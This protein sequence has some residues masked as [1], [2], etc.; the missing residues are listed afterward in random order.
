[1]Y[2]DIIVDISHENLDREFQY[3]IPEKLKE[4]AVIGAS[5]EIPF[6]S[7]N[8]S[9]K[10][11]IVGISD[12]PKI[13]AERIKPLLSIEP[14]GIRIESRMIALAGKMR[15]MYGGTMNDALRTVMPVKRSIRPVSERTVSLACSHEE[16]ESF[17]NEAERKHRTAQVR[18]IRELIGEPS[19]D[20]LLLVNKL[21][22]SR[23]TISDL[24]SNGI[25]RITTER[26]YRNPGQAGDD[27]KKKQIE[28]NEEQQTAIDAV[29]SDYHT[30]KRK[31][32][33][34]HGV[35]G[36]GKTEVYL[37]VIEEVVKLGY[38]VIM[39]IPEIALT[40]Q[41]M[42]RFQ[43]RFGM[44]VSFL[45]SR[46]SEGERYDQYT[47]AEQGEIDI[48]IGPRSA[49]FTPFRNPGLIIIDEEHENSYKSEQVPKYHAR[50]LAIEYAKMISA[51]VVL[52]SATPSLE[53]FYRAKTGEYRLL[54][55]TN[56][57]GNAQMP[58]VHIVDMREELKARNLSIFSR[59]LRTLIEDRLLHHQQVMLF[60]NRRGFA[61]FVSCRNCGESMQ[62]PHCAVSLTA[63][64][65]RRL[66]CHYCGYEQEMPQVCPVCGSKYIA[67]FGTGTEKVEAMVQREFPTAK[68]LRMDADTTRK[69]EGHEQILAAF[70]NEEADILVGTQMIVKGHDF[71]RVTLMGVLA[72]DLSLS[73]TDYR[74]AERTFQLLAQAAGRSGR[75]EEAGEVVIQTYR[76]EHYSIQAA[77]HEDYES[78]YRNEMMYRTA[79]GYPPA[80]NLAAILL[81]AKEEEEA[82][83]GAVF[84]TDWVKAW[85]EENDSL[86]CAIVIGPAPAGIAKLRDIYRRVIYIKHPDYPILT[87]CRDAVEEMLR[88]EDTLRE[89]NIQFDFNPMNNY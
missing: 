56:R 41:T 48:M 55:L 44:R 69:K 3:S 57:A 31:T 63:H 82:E 85:M 52:G 35:T 32:Y 72:A 50:E 39:L 38:Q 28:L 9:R 59:Q 62:C 73:S 43:Q 75:A 30:D 7:G 86:E 8:K 58:Q 24:E 16:A 65:N 53:A 36:S 80:S 10:G 66:I 76:P 89:C 67:A 13:A 18:L 14:R 70:A 49:L 11:Y 64:N 34:L 5:V 40:Y 33:L 23:K 1:M 45:H 37:S 47:R 77:A 6:G 71:G 19:T 25:L 4:Q 26:Q 84:L 12:K 15:E 46:L 51:S 27:T 74:A 17:L 29:I 54:R 88:E 60:I 83:A 79:M 61:G 20:Y 87:E 68:V 42:K 21:N 22:I 81:T 2:A 78:F